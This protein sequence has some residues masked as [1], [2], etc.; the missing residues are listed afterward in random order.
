MTYSSLLEQFEKRK[1]TLAAYQELE[2]LFKEMERLKNEMLELETAFQ[3]KDY[4]EY[5]IA[6]DELITK[7]TLLESH[8]SVINQ[9]L[10][11]INRR[12]QQYTR[13]IATQQAAANAGVVVSGDVTAA[14]GMG[15]ALKIY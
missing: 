12:A 6:N 7:H 8:K 14:A 15:N 4:G 2:S 10:K 9:H 5:Y 3:S 11:S 1:A 13:L